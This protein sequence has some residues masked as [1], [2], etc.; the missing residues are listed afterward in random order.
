MNEAIIGNITAG[1]LLAWVILGLLVGSFVGR[2]VRRRQ[3]GFGLIGNLVIG[4]VGAVIGGFLFDALDVQLGRDVVLSLND[5]IAA[6]CGALIFIALV[7]LI[8]R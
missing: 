5:F 6:F 1:Q 7:T 2:I 3:R 8:R 4:L